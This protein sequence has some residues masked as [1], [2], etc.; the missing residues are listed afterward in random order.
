MT[1]V[2]HNISNKLRR[3]RRTH[4]RVHAEPGRPKLVITRSN[5]FI[6]L[7][8]I[9]ENGKVLASCGDAA[10]IKKGDLKRSLTKTECATE[11]GKCM[12]GLL[13]KAKIKR[14]AVDRGAY[15]FHGR[16]KAAVEAIRENGIE[17]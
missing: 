7:Q 11:V 8:A 15:K 6:D 17:A 12:A 10:M 5:R 4:G 1:Q 9:G 2:Q 13:K 14:V 3:S 16:I